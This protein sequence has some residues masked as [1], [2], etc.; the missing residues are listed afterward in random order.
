MENNPDVWVIVE[1]F[2]SDVR[3]VYRRVLAGWFGGYLGGDSWQLSSGVTKIIDRGK[4]WEIHNVSGSIY[5]CGKNDE[6][7]C[8]I[9]ADTYRRLSKLNND[10]IAMKIISI[11]ECI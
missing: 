3:E 11:E 4:Y 7:L 1:L 5:N 8:R 10:K 2:G 6:R 9:T